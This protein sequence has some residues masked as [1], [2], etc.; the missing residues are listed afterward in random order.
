MTPT[1]EHGV[2]SD[3]TWIAAVSDELIK[4][5]KGLALEHA[6]DFARDLASRERWRLLAPSVAARKA[7]EG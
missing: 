6:E 7:F 5:D 4:L 2:L 1:D 3:E